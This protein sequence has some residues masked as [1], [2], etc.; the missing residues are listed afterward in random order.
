MSKYG[1][2]TVPSYVLTS[3]KRTPLVKPWLKDDDA[4]FYINPDWEVPADAKF[5][6]AFEGR[7]KIQTHYRVWRGHQEMMKLFV[8]TGKPIGLFFEDDAVPN[9][10]RY[11]DIVNACVADMHQHQD[12]HVFNTYGRLFD[13]KRFRV[14][15]TVANRPLYV[16]K[17]D[18]K[19]TEEGGWHCVLGSLA[20]LMTREAADHFS[21]LPWSGWPIDQEIPDTFKGCFGF[22]EPSP[23]DHDRSQGSLVE[24]KPATPKD[25]AAVRIRKKRFL[26]IGGGRRLYGNP[27]RLK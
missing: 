7:L 25:R 2:L 26:T 20:Y 3:P 10:G 5:V 23:W 13:L 11:K 27:T 22:I 16:L 1:Q 24:E 15:R 17:D 4:T 19:Q 8:A 9:T 14:L 12:L 6:P 21:N 18:A